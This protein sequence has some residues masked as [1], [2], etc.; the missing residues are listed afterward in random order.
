MHLLFRATVRC[1][2]RFGPLTTCAKSAE[3]DLPG[4]HASNLRPELRE[5]AKRHFSE[6]GWLLN[7]TEA[8]IDLCP[9]HN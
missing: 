9:D 8:G 2:Y 7:Q 3:Y 6:A 1:G 4:I 5:N